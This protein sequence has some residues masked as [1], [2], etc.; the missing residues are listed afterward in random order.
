MPRS[1]RPGKLWRT[2]VGDCH[3]IWVPMTHYF[4]ECVRCGAQRRVSST[5]QTETINGQPI[6]WLPIEGDDHE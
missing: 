4:E 1:R 5:V 3:H 2:C 6:E